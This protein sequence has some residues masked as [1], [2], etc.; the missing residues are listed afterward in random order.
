MKKIFLIGVFALGLISVSFANSAANMNEANVSV[1]N[2]ASDNDGWEN[3]GKA[4]ATSYTGHWDGD[5]YVRN[6]YQG[7]LYVKIIASKVLYK[8][9]YEGNEYSVVI[10]S[11]SGG[12]L[13][14]GYVT[15]YNEKCS[16]P[17]PFADV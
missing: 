6:E 13:N 4:T 16:I 2:G 11:K 9:V 1:E 15:I 3:L 10:H 12:A 17:I 8:F 7:I 5:S 14:Y